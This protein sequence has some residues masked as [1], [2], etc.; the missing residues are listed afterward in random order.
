MVLLELWE[1][2]KLSENYLKVSHEVKASNNYLFYLR[3]CFNGP[4]WVGGKHISVIGLWH[5]LQLHL[6]LPFQSILAAVPVANCFRAAFCQL[7]WIYALYWSTVWIS[8]PTTLYIQWYCQQSLILSS[9]VTYQVQQISSQLYKFNEKPYCFCNE[10]LH[11]SFTLF[12]NIR[13]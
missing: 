7:K 6:L 11:L 8:A 13:V 3:Y 5:R 10:L 12:Y 2:V 9:Y 1:T 4:K